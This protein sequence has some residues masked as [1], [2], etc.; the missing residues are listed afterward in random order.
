M[1]KPQSLLNNIVVAHAAMASFRSWISVS[2][3]SHQ[4]AAH[5]TPATSVAEDWHHIEVLALD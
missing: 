1:Q 3:F 2:I 4:R 5:G